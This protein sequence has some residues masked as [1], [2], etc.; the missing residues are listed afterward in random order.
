MDQTHRTRVVSTLVVG[1]LVVGL[2]PLALAGSSTASGGT[3]L[4]RDGFER[5]LA[6]WSKATSATRLDR[7]GLGRGGGSAA[8]LR[9]PTSSAATVAMTD[10]PALVRSSNRAVRYRAMVW[11]RATKDALRRGSVTVRLTFGERTASGPGPTG[12]QQ[13]HLRDTRWRGVVVP[14]TSRRDGRSLDVTVHAYNVPAGGA[15][16]VDDVSIRRVP[17]PSV[18]DRVLAGTRFGAS[19]DEGRLEYRAAL[20]R[21]DRRYGRLEVVRVFE[22]FIRDSWSG[23]VGQIKRPLLVSF[24]ASPAEVVDGRHDAQLRE[25]FRDAPKSYPVW[26]TYYHEPEDNIERG[27]ITAGKYR[28]AWRHINAIARRTGGANLH[29]T[30]TLMAWTARPESGRSVSDYYPGSFIDVMAWDGYN[31]PDLPGYRPPKHMF[32]PAVTAAKRRDAKFA[33]AEL[34]SRLE[35]GDEGSRRAA[36]LVRVARYTAKHDAVFV[37]YWDARLPGENY[38]L[39]DLPSILAWRSVVKGKG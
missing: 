31:P 34:G 4:A 2:L 24:K 3:L 20:R 33:V 29:P 12:W 17:R 10:S 16:L 26:W 36:W 8:R 9:P 32:G 30:L 27:E 19:V 39:R 22:P 37:S 38:Q 18:P 23:L 14:L 6:R 35:P 11:V 1:L 25:W 13:V 7:V 5:S 21:S 15:V 28:E